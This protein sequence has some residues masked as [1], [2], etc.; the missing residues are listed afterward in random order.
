[1]SITRI[2][3]NTE[4]LLAGSYLAKTEYQLS[5]TMARLSS[6]LRINTGADDPSGVALA[7]GFTAQIGGTQMAIQNA[8]DALSIMQLADAAMNSAMDIMLRMRD[9]AVKAASDV[10]V[11]TAQRKSMEQEYVS[12][13]SE[14]Q[15]RK[16]QTTFNSKTLFAGSM[17]GKQVQIGPNNST[18]NRMSIN[19]PVLS[20]GGIGAAGGTVGR[21]LLIAHVSGNTGTRAQSAIQYIQSCI[22]NLADLQSAV[23]VQEAGL[24]RVIDDLSSANVNMNAARSRIQDADMA[25]E[26]SEF[27]R[28]QVI[29]QSATAM[30]AQANA[31]PQTVM[32]L[33]GLAG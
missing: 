30:I 20:V 4:A 21:S 22:N 18:S 16:T 23:G 1:M 29:S 14:F 11:T 28:A 17:V 32:K 26:V 8:Q 6:G 12:L 25:A 15:R 7:K 9:I 24:Q 3:T 2:N 31:Q 13:K 5:K 27:A 19:V 10:T 33:L